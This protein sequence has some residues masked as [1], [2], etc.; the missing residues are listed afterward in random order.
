MRAAMDGSDPDYRVLDGLRVAL[1]QILSDYQIR[2]LPPRERGTS[3]VMPEVWRRMLR[4]SGQ[5]L[6]GSSARLYHG[7]GS[8]EIDV[9]GAAHGVQAGLS[10]RAVTSE[11]QDSCDDDAGRAVSAAC[12]ENR[13]YRRAVMTRTPMAETSVQEWLHE[14]T[15]GC[16][17]RSRTGCGGL[18]HSSTKGHW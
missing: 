6:D 18:L 7:E 11:H 13:L 10:G 12:N 3:L 17:R 14:R 8:K 4:D 5:L 1:H 2:I 9:K 15:D 16:G